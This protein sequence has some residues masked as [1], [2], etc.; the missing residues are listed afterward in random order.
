MGSINKREKIGSGKNEIGKLEGVKLG[1]GSEREIRDTTGTGTGKNVIRKET[2]K[3]VIG[4]QTGKN[5]I[6]KLKRERKGS[7][8]WRGKKTGFF[9]FNINFGTIVKSMFKFPPC[10]SYP[11]NAG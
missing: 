2:G 11:S 6:R 9:K 5:G 7:G 3:N 1:L 4:K 10:L 8:N